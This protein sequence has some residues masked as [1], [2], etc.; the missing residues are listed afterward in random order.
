M[1]VGMLSKVCSKSWTSLY[2]CMTYASSSS[3]TNFTSALESGVTRW[4][5]HN[6]KKGEYKKGGN[7]FIL[8][9]ML[10]IN[11][12]QQPRFRCFTPHRPQLTLSSRKRRYSLPKEPSGSEAILFRSSVDSLILGLSLWSTLDKKQRQ[13]SSHPTVTHGRDVKTPKPE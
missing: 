1:L 5:K 6:L 10:L 7:V 3:S 12:M 11:V 9:W 13:K 8:H 2:L 4:G